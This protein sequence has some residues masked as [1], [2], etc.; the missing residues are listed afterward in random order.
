MLGQLSQYLP[1]EGMKILIV[2]FL[3]FL[4]GLEREEHKAEAEHYSF[5]GVRTF[6]LIGLVGYV[7][8]LLSGG[9][10][11]PLSIG[12]AVVGSFLLMS[13]RH[14]LLLQESEAEAPG[15]TTEISGLGTY[16]LGAL[17]MKG[18]NVG[19]VAR[20]FRRTD[21]RR[22]VQHDNEPLVRSIESSG[23]RND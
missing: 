21:L 3:S 1:S 7:M 20:P 4:I 9:Q 13:Y 14:K 2:L 18:R 12:F 8:A 22:R 16:L 17:A 15:V 11:L 10:L 19:E 5:G 23:Q 6:P